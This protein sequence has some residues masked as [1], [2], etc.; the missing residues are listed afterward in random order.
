MLT[1]FLYFDKNDV[2]TFLKYVVNICPKAPT[3]RTGRANQDKVSRIMQCP[4]KYQESLGQVV[5]PKKSSIVFSKN[6]RRSDQQ[7]LS[8][9]FFQRIAPLHSKSLSRYFFK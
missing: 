6:V 2:K 8:R 3:N 5:S 4:P 1:N 9:S 7:S